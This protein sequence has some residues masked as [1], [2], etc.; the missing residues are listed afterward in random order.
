[1]GSGSWS[2]LSTIVSQE[3]S[4]GSGTFVFIKNI[5]KKLKSTLSSHEGGNEDNDIP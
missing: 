2:V 4:I 1:M 3:L 5:F